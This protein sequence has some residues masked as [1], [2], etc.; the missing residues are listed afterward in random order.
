MK[1]KSQGEE[2]KNVPMV[3][4][5]LDEFNNHREGGSRTER[6]SKGDFER[7]IEWNRV[8]TFVHDENFIA[9][10]DYKRWT[11]VWE[12]RYEATKVGISHIV[13]IFN[14]YY[15]VTITSRENTH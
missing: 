6:H 12:R 15:R 11:L 3:S 14:D 10:Q 7:R 4:L 9:S 2:K 13:L 1:K 5:K 8:C